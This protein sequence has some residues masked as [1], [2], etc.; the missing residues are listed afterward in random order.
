MAVSFE[1]E[2]ENMNAA[3]TRFTKVS[4]EELK[5]ILPDQVVDGNNNHGSNRKNKKKNKEDVGK[6]TRRNS[7]A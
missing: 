3:K 4:V 5:K 7:K 6:T 1:I 2:A